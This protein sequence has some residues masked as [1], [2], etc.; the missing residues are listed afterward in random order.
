MLNLAIK[1]AMGWVGDT[2]KEIDS[3]WSR[4]SLRGVITK[5]SRMEC[6]F[7]LKQINQ[8]KTSYKLQKFIFLLLLLYYF[9]T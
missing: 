3:G 4:N 1:I 8:P 2:G 6:S 9:T 5:P 7:A